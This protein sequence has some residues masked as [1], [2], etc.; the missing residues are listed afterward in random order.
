MQSVYQTNCVGLVYNVYINMLI[1]PSALL[2]QPQNKFANCK[3]Y[4]ESQEKSI[5]NGRIFYRP[6]LIHLLHVQRKCCVIRKICE[7][8]HT[9]QNLIF[10][11]CNSIFSFHLHLNHMSYVPL[12][13]LS[14]ELRVCSPLLSVLCALFPS[15]ACPMSYVPLCCLSYE[16]CSPLLPVLCALFPST[17]TVL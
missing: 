6:V 7:Y 9:V 11:E 17:V 4:P 13:C 14:Y 5:K 8:K 3:L 1:K 16:L 10:L 15:A 12:G 2:A